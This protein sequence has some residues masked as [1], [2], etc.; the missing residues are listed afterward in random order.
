MNAFGYRFEFVAAD[1]SVLPHGDNLGNVQA[2]G[3]FSVRVHAPIDGPPV[4]AE[5]LVDELGAGDFQFRPKDKTHDITH[6]TGDRSYQPFR[7]HKGP[8]RIVIVLAGPEDVLL[9]T[10]Y[11]GV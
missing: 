2:G 7:F 11:T 1:G 9:T 6:F 4:T 3:R 8:G 10:H 5:I